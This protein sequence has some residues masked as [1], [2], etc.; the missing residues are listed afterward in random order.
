MSK[1][2]IAGSHSNSVL[3]FLRIYRFLYMKVRDKTALELSW[4]IC[5]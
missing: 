3:K 4:V 2:E 5:E 1:S